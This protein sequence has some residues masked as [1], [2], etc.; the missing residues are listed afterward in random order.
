[1]WPDRVSNQGP[2]SY[3]SGARPTALRGPA[4]K[5]SEIE[6]VVLENTSFQCVLPY[7][8]IVV[9]FNFK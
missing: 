9:I 2:L 3:E 6:L 5:T 4:P 7:V 1:M 8:G